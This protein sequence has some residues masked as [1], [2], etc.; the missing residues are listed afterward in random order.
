MTGFGWVL[1]IAGILVA[2]RFGFPEFLLVILGTLF[3]VNGV[4]H[5]ASS[6]ATA[7]YNPGL[8]TG[9]LIWGPLG[10]V[11]LMPLHGNMRGVRFLAGMAIGAGIQG[12]V[13]LLSLSGGKFSKA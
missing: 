4:L 10:A 6:V 12:A 2:D 11:T 13:S 8:L 9:T 5:L 3:L 1:M 7:K